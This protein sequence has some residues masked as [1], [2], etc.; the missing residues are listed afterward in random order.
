MNNYMV[1]MHISPSNKRYIGITSMN[2]ENIRWQNGNGYK[3]N[4]HF[5]RAIEKY[6]WDNFQHII[7]ARNLTKEEACWLE[8]ELIREWD[9]A[10]KNKGYNITLGGEGSNGLK[11]SKK[12]KQQ[13]SEKMSGE[14]NPMYGKH[15]T[16]EVKEKLRKIQLSLGFN[17]KNSVAI[18]CITTMRIFPSLREG[19]RF[20]NTHHGSISECCNKNGRLK[21]AGKLEDGT[22]LVW[23]YLIIIEL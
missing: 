18:I 6:G 12:T 23:R 19:A 9:S 7:I 14:N 22:P 4:K 11:H 5:Y 3:H 15:H 17:N 16:E 10:N 20:Y 13:L 2:D 1:Y 21:S 8:I